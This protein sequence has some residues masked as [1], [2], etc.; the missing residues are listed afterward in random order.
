MVGFARREGESMEG[1]GR[2]HVVP[3]GCS[4]PAD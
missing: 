4:S 3:D 1:E 2:A